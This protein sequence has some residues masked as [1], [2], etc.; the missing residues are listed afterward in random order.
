MPLHS[1]PVGIKLGYKPETC[2]VT[3]DYGERVLRLP[4]YADMTKDDVAKVIEL[5]HEYL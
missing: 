1:S 2:P 4:L 3:E 5:I